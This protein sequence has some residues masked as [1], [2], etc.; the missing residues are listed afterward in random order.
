MSPALE[1]WANYEKIKWK[2]T[3]FISKFNLDY[4]IDSGLTNLNFNAYS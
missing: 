4:C 2:K 3:T 1:G